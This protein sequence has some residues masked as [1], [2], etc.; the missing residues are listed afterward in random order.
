MIAC[1]VERDTNC[2]QM[3]THMLEASKKGR[4]LEKGAFIGLIRDRCT[5]EIGLE[6]YHMEKGNT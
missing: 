6:A 4:N 5:Q 2:K 1:L 3:G